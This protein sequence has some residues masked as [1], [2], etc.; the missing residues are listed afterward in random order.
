M[1]YTQESLR[2]YIYE[3]T[4]VAF[5]E[6]SPD[7]REGIR[8][9]IDQSLANAG[10]LADR[11]PPARIPLFQQGLKPGGKVPILV[12]PGD[13]HLVVAGGIEA[14]ISITGWSYMRAPYTWGS[15][16]TIKIKGATLTQSGR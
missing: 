2:N 15:H 4:S 3:A 14:G 1:G 7:E 12:A 8:K 6:L 9:R 10:I 13:L 11:I 16:Q 5:E